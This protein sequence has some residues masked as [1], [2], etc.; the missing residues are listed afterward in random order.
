MSWPGR[1]SPCFSA[2]GLL[3]ILW[4]AIGT[5]CFEANPPRQSHHSPVESKAVSKPPLSDQSSQAVVEP[6]GARDALAHTRPVVSPSSGDPLLPSQP[7]TAELLRATGSMIIAETTTGNILTVKAGPADAFPRPKLSD[8][9]FDLLAQCNMLAFLKLDR[10]GLTDAN[11]L[12]LAPLTQLQFID[13][14]GNDVTDKGAAVFEQFEGLGGV[15]ISDTKISDDGVCSFSKNARLTAFFANNLALTDRAAECISQ[16]P[17]LSYLELADSKISNV[18]L[19]KLSNLRHMSE[20]NLARTDINDDGLELLPKFRR[21]IVLD[22]SGCDIQGRGLVPLATMRIEW[23]KLNDTPITDDGLKHLAN[24][25][26]PLVIELQ[27]TALSQEAID[28]L[29][30]AL[31]KTGIRF[32]PVQPKKSNDSNP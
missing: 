16:M 7:T 4:I 27:R 28:G 17:M 8:E 13:L 15:K 14:S 21:L 10:T 32:S 31:P 3:G 25:P 11:L 29:K 19:A 5:G 12:K 26:A 18:G 30:K 20:L 22:L 2:L 6:T 9:H 23:L 24:M 1:T